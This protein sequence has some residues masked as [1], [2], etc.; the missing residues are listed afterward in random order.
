MSTRTPREIAQNQADR[1]N[2]QYDLEQ[3]QDR[4][5][6]ETD[7]FNAAGDREV[8]RRQFDEALA[9]KQMD[10]ATALAKE[11][12]G[13]AKS[14]SKAAKWAAAATGLAALGAIAQAVIAAWK[15]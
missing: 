13:A 1:R 3:E 7:L 4:R 10:H 2:R 11:Q 5:K 14:A 9:Q 15:S 12:V 8:K 6:F